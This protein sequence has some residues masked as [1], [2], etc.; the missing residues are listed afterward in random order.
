MSIS[1]ISVWVY[2]HLGEGRWERMS[3]AW[4]VRFYNGKDRV[5]NPFSAEVELAEILVA[6][7]GRIPVEVC[8]TVFMKVP[9][10]P[11][12]LIDELR[13]RAR[14]RTLMEAATPEFLLPRNHEK[15]ALIEHSRLRFARRRADYMAKWQPSQRDL[16]GLRA[17]LTRRGVPR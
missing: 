5:P 6:R 10:H 8:R 12:G 17:E 14:A 9:I 15:R 1:S 11:S 13:E 7:E 16:Q 3:L 2:L 4:L